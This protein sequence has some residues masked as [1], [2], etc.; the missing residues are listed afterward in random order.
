MSDPDLTLLPAEPFPLDRRDRL[1]GELVALVHA[2]SATRPRRKLNRFMLAGGAAVL[3]VAGGGTAAAI[4]YFGSTPVTDR[5]SARCYSAISTDF[6]SEFPGTTIA[7][8]QA[9]DGSGGQVVAPIEACAAAWRVGIP[10]GIP[11]NKANPPYPVPNLAGC[12]L[13]DGSAAVFPGPA[14]TCQRLGL[15]T[16]IPG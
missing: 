9:S 2:D 11:P 10:Q 4:A 13:P 12:V 14:D 8:A 7:A 1:R 16:A 3:V 6:G 5:T 15:P